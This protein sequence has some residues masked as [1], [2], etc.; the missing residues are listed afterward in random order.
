[1]RRDLFA[2]PIFEDKVDL[3]KI[4]IENGVY[5]PTWDSGVHSSF[6]SDTDVPTE[7]WEHI[8]EVVIKNIQ[9][10]ECSYKDARI[11]SL[12]RNVYTE[13]DY[14][15]LHIHPNCQWSFIIYESVPVSKTVLHNPSF[16]DIQ[17][18]IF[19][20]GLPDFPLDYKPQLESGSIIIFP[21]FIMHSVLHGSKGTTIAGNIKLTYQP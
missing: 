8:T 11:D 1:M 10:I 5:E 7:T 9:T 16:K 17:N 2:I 15:E 6:G 12:W 19:H 18:Q 4:H 3:N 14:Q 13:T 21:S 20:T